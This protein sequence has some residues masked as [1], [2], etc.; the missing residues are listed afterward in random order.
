MKKRKTEK[1]IPEAPMTATETIKP[2]GRT[3]SF[4]PADDVRPLLDSARA[5][6]LELS[7]LIN[8]SLRAHGK[9]VAG[10][11]AD[12]MRKRL[13]QFQRGQN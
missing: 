1:K 9:A 6:G 7:T 3:A 8:E 4:S 2:L 11:L 13:E 10:E 5:A 12:S